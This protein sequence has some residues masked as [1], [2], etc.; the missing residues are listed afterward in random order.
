MKD[1]GRLDRKITIQSWTQQRG[2]YGSMEDVWEDYK[3]VWARYEPIQNV[4]QD[5]KFKG[6]RESGEERVDFIVRFD[7]GINDKRRLVYNGRYFDIL[8]VYEYVDDRRR[9]RKNY[10]RILAQLKK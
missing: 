2:T 10:L 5:E 8:S 6:D 7:E 9:Q 4:G 1:I 3:T